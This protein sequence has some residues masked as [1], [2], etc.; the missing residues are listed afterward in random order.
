MDAPPRDPSEAS[1]LSIRGTRIGWADLVDRRL[2]DPAWRAELRAAMQAAQ[3]YPHLVTDG[4]FHP[5]L[6]RCVREE[7]DLHPFHDGRELDRRYEDTVRSPRNPVLGPACQ[8]YFAIVQSGWFLALLSELS[9]VA[10]LIADPTLHNGGLHESRR[11]GHF[12]IHAD[13]ET[14]SCSGLHSEMVLIT[15]LNP[16]WDPSWGGALELWD[17]NG[18]ACVRRVEPEFGRCILMRNGPRHFHGHPTPLNLPE[19]QVRR[20][21][22]AY[23]YANRTGARAARTDSRYLRVDRLDWLRRGA[24]EL[25]P[26]L[27]WRWMRRLVR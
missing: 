15:Y 3:P 8:A 9:G 5:D 27:V 26:P 20:S 25:T 17:T 24:R 4:W 18:T 21:V 2:H 23:Y 7:F 11:G 13:F 22:V 12:R 14:S 6:L 1:F 19:H 10:E 16:G